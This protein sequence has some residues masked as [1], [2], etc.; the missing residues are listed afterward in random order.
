MSSWSAAREWIEAHRDWWFD[1]VRVYLG[2]GLFVKGIQFVQ[3]DSFLVQVLQQSPST[4]FKFRF[5]ETFAL[6]YIPLAHI[7]GGLLLAVGLMTRIS[8]M[9]QLPVLIGAVLLAYSGDGIFTHDQEFQFTALV[10]WLLLM[11]LIRGSGRLSVDH[12]LRTH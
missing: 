9:F 11:I 6:H 4:P 8:T 5:L 3:D 2:I 7:G 10:L 12:Y 1:L